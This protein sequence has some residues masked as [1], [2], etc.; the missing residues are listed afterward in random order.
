MTESLQ[1][2]REE[3]RKLGLI[4]PEWLIRLNPFVE[5]DFIIVEDSVKGRVYFPRE[6]FTVEEVQKRYELITRFSN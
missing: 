6:Q 2:L 5:G 4:I 1:Q 3:Y